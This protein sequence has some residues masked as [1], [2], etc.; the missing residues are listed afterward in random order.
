MYDFKKKEIVDF[1]PEY[2]FTFKAPV[3][4]KLEGNEDLEKQVYQ[5]LFLD[6]FGD[7]EVNG[8][9]TLNY[10]EKKDEKALYYKKFS[11]EPSPVKFTIKTFLSSSATGIREKVRTPTVSSERSVILR[12]T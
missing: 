6:V 10:S 7:P 11:H 4:L 2:F 5:K 8:D 3:E 1:S 9:G 12:T